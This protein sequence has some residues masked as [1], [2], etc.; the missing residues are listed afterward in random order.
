MHTKI[1]NLKHTAPTWNEEFQLPEGSYSLS[2]IQ[3][4]F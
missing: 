1:I 3:E 2:D 4:Y